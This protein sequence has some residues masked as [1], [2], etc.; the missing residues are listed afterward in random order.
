MPDRRKS[1]PPPVPPVTPAEQ[2]ALDAL[3]HLADVVWFI[4]WFLDM[5]HSRLPDPLDAEAM[6]TGEMPESLTFSLRGYIE[7]ARHDYVSPLYGTLKDAAAET[8]AQLVGD[9]LRRKLR[10][11]R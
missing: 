5:I 7:C 6:G 3:K 4:E 2:E 10:E 1:T 9:W 11:G 8:P